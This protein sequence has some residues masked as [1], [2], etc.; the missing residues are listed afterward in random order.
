M[1]C[2]AASTALLSSSTSPN[3]PRPSISPKSFLS[4]QTLS[5]PSS[6][7][8]LRKS[9]PSFSSLS[10]VPCS[11][12]SRSSF[13]NRRSFVVRA[14]I[15]LRGLFIIDKEGVIQHATINN[16]AIGRSVD[17]SLRTLQDHVASGSVATMPDTL[18]HLST[19]SSITPP[20][21]TPK[22]PSLSRPKHAHLA[23]PPPQPDSNS[24]SISIPS[25]APPSSSSQENNNIAPPLKFQ[26]LQEKLL[27]LDSLGLDSL[28]C[29]AA[30][31]PIL[32]TPLSQIKSLV[33]F[34]HSLGLTT[35]DLRRAFSMCPDLLATPLRTVLRPAV[36]FL[37]REAHVSGKDLRHV[38]NRRPRL[39][40]CSVDRRLRP[41]L[42]FLRGTIG[43]DDVSRSQRL[44]LNVYYKDEGPEEIPGSSRP[45]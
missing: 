17:E 29:L 9:S 28:Y 33:K 24:I 7:N 44:L 19:S 1:A 2:S 32:F 40:I 8:T 13:P 14:G 45:G 37:L 12:S 23:P 11:F 31:S 21:I 18:H 15:A 16:L 5:T 36:T 20:F 34:L 10:H 25:T 41:T 6:F 39:L 38:I 4:S 30:H 35:P 22:F 27:Y 42:Y 26:L 3:P 43:I